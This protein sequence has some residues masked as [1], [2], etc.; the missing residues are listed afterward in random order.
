MK[1]NQDVEWRVKEACSGQRVLGTGFLLLWMEP[2][3]QTSLNG[4][5]TRQR[6]FP[7]TATALG[8]QRLLLHHCTIPLIG[9]PASILATPSSMTHSVPAARVW[10]AFKMKNRMH[11][12]CA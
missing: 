12:S 4:Q 3:Q 11:F 6:H 2:T 7:H 1:K 10:R 8:H 5:A 9:L